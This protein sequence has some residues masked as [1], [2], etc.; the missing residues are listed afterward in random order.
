MMKTTILFLVSLLMVH[1][2]YSG[3]ISGELRKWHKVTIDFTGP[4]VDEKSEDNPFMNYRLNVT[5]VH[6]S[7]GQEYIVPGYFAA[8]GDAANSSATSGDVWRVHFAPDQEGEWT[9]SV[10]FRKGR[11]VAISEKLGT[12]V[13]GE[14]MDRESGSF[15]ILPTDKTGRDFRAKGRLDYLGGHYLQFQETKEYFIKQGPDAPENFLSYVDFDGT[16]H[17]DGHKDNL[18]KKWEAH[19]KDWK[20]GDPT[21]KDGKGKAIIGATNYLA[22]EGLNSVSFLTMN[23]LGDDQ[24]VF[25]YV[26]YD[27]YDRMDVSK[28]AQW[29]IVFEH[30]QKLG[31]FLHFKTTEVE[32]QGLLDNG[33]VGAHRKLYYRELIA[34]FG[35]HLALNWNMCEESGDWVKNHK[36]PPQFT[37]QRLAMASY[38]YNHDPYRHHVVIHNGN[39]FTDLLGPDSKYTGASIQ[40]HRADFGHVHHATLKWRNESAQ[41]GKPWA[42]AVDEPGDA[43]HSLVPD[44]D[45]PDHNDAR[46]NALWGAMTAGAWGVEWYFGYKHDHS[47]L[48][49][50]DYRSRDLF[51]DQ[52]RY[53]Q[54][55]FSALP[56]NDM[57][58][59]DELIDQENYGF[60]KDGE[61]YVFVLR[62]GGSASVDLSA[63]SDKLKGQWF[64]PRTGEYLKK[65]FTVEAA[66]SVSI[67]APKQDA[68]KDWVVVLTK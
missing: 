38:F 47:D 68:D 4:S 30:A 17:N 28:L 8:D 10:D 40:T 57:R 16:F 54:Q 59:A 55:F 2:S 66:K 15:T 32:N 3:V 53:A 7:S 12:G 35:H 56:V 46:V 44:K 67:S 49:C 27:T 62:K 52:C 58:P 64:N 11:W 43:Q 63:A 39:P 61:L 26:D 1:F 14:F 45:D 25:P 22:S 18:V 60:V 31:L 6:K 65:G 36:T 51:W 24:N 29:E 42:V 37:D 34:R 21:W 20:D 5:F 50:E 33:G 23:I 48:S 19:L 41:A 9:Y 13:P